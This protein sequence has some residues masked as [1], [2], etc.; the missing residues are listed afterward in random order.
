MNPGSLPADVYARWLLFALT[1]SAIGCSFEAGGLAVG[2]RDNAYDVSCDCAPMAVTQALSVVGE[3]DD[4]EEDVASGSVDLTSSDLELVEDGGDPQLVGIRFA[5]LG[6]PRGA[7]LLGARIQFT[8][9]ETTE[10]PTS[11]EIRAVAADDAPTFT[12]ADGDIS[13]RPLGAASVPWAPAPWTVLDEAGPDQLTPDLAPV[14]QEL[15]DRPGWTQD[16][17]AAFVITGT[18]QRVAW[19]RDRSLAGAPRLI[20]EYQEAGVLFEVSA[21]VPPDL[22]PNP[23]VGGHAPTPAELD[24]DLATRVQP[25]LEGLASSCGY[26]SAC[27][28]TVVPS[29]QQFAA[30]CDDP[31]VEEPLAPDCGNFDPVAGVTTATNAPGDTPVC[32]THSPLASA[33]Y[34]LRSRCE[35]SGTATVETE[36]E[37]TKTPAASG[38][39]EFVG[40]PCPGQS[41][42]VGMEYALEI[43]AITYSNLFGSATFSD[44]SS[45]GTSVPGGDVVLDGAGTGVF[46]PASVAFGA[47]GQR[48]GEFRETVG[49][50]DNDVAVGVGW[51]EPAPVCDLV[52]TLV[53]NVDPELMRCEPAG[54]DADAICTS[55]A[56]CTDDPACSD[57][58]CDCLPVPQTEQAM[59]LDVGGP[60]VNQPPS[61]DAGPDQVVECNLPGAA[62]FQLDALS[63]DPDGDLTL[64]RWYLGSRTGPEVGFAPQVTIVQSVASSTDYVVRVID[65]FG[66]ADED[67]TQVQVA[68]TT[69][70]VLS[71]NA[72]ATILPGTHGRAFTATAADVCDPGAT[73]VITAYRCEKNG[74]PHPCKVSID[75]DTVT[76]INSTGVGN[77]ISWDVSV[78]DASGNVT[79]ETCQIEVATH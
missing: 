79:S 71:C 40:S 60:I 77:V 16:S 25:T 68:D 28:C 46:G 62:I 35:V 14:L 31:C 29:S 65:S 48:D 57:E 43:D 58:V 22:N 49:T 11:L 30:T 2:G 66:Q 24:L 52:G 33:M 21:C 20:V 23:G 75:G 53:G 13:S 56:D 19:S 67:T 70:P 47:R 54:P 73:P 10:A 78:T 9:D 39:I 12:D 59:S 4:A 51:G 1:A 36:G 41:C 34:G 32:T 61:A 45:V 37:D 8:V 26:P 44:L 15:V 38:V 69:A 5:S 42:S 18:G 7:V 17:A 72:P 63:S 76:I 50:N 64:T 74:K 27:A 55:G 3:T 6:I